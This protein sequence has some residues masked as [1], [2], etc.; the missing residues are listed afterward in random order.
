MKDKIRIGVFRENLLPYTETFILNQARFITKYSV[1]IFGINRITP[2]TPFESIYVF[3]SMPK[4][5]KTIFKLFS[6]IPDVWF[7]SFKDRKYALIHAHF[8]PDA[9]WASAF[10][11]K[12]GIP[13][14]TTFHGYDVFPT[15]GN[16][17]KMYH[18]YEFRRKELFNRSSK[19]IAVSEYVKSRLLVLGC[20]EDKI[21]VHHI[22]IDTDYFSPIEQIREPIILFV[23]RL[24]KQKGIL[25]LINASSLIKLQNRS[26]KIVVIGSGDMQ[27]EAAKLANSKSVPI[28]FLGKKNQQEVKEW[29]NRAYILC[30]PSMY[31][32]LGMVYAEAQAM[33]LPIVA[34]KH[35]GPPEI[36]VDGTSGLLCEPGDIVSLSR[37]I[38]D[39]LSDKILRDTMGK[40]GRNL[41]VSNY[42]ILI[43]TQKLEDIYHRVLKEWGYEK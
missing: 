27:E 36:V 4:I 16:L 14:I 42:N 41:M 17:G 31:E 33:E 29:M 32:A 7:S 9:L 12:L 19:V 26:L 13:L 38:E 34:Y 6:N 22:G 30:V 11:K 21:E 10:S 24:I 39:L 35:G 15:Q 1:E 37:A 20:P 23:G 25:D 2:E 28:E 43:Q 40:S 8:G 18:Y 5:T 3:Q